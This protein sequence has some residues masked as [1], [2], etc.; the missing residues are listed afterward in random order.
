MGRLKELENTKLPEHLLENLPSTEP[1]QKNIENT[2]KVF[3]DAQSSSDESDDEPEDAEKVIDTETTKFKVVT[4][5]DLR[6][7]KYRNND[8]WTFRERMLFGSRIKRGDFSK[9]KSMNIKLEV[10]GNK[11]VILD[12]I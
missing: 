5:T 11:R 9:K 7:D 1:V 6:S 3:N 10:S 8:A 4:N 2:K 12:S